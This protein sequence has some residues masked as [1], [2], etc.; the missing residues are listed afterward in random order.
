MASRSLFVRVR[1]YLGFEFMTGGDRISPYRA[2]VHLHCVASAGP[3]V[4]TLTALAEIVLRDM[5]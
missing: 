2:G 5:R 1:E 4:V 3:H